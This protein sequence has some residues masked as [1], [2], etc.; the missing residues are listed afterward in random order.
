[1]TWPCST[2]IDKQL[3]LFESPNKEGI[4]PTQAWLLLYI[5]P[6][7]PQNYASSLEHHP[8]HALRLPYCME[9]A[10]VFP[11]GKE[12]IFYGLFSIWRQSQPEI[13]NEQPSKTKT[14]CGLPF[15]NHRTSER[16]SEA[17]TKAIQSHVNIVSSRSN[18][19]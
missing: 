8:H 13:S 4:C 10:G 12:R 15:P 9:D 14:S 18:P 19:C 7:L 1:M 6:Q 11:V 16:S 3:Q 17:P 2:A 5:W